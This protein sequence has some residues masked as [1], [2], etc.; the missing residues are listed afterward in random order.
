METVIMS[1]VLGAIFAILSIFKDREIQR[2]RS[3]LADEMERGDRYRRECDSII[4]T[5]QKAKED[6]VCDVPHDSAHKEAS[7]AVGLFQSTLGLAAE[8]KAKRTARELKKDIT[9]PACEGTQEFMG[10]ECQSCEG[11]GKVIDP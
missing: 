3:R 7:N 4:N 10:F 1:V 2:L 5:L 9:C 6:K 8:I 11:T